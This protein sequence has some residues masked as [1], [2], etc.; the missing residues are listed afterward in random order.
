MLQI[1]TNRNSN[2]AI[3]GRRKKRPIKI[4]MT[5][6]HPQLF[7]L[8]VK[9]RFSLSVL[10]HQTEYAIKNPTRKIGPPVI[11]LSKIPLPSEI[12]KNSKVLL[13]LLL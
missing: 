12:S 4:N 13:L 10:L 7:W 9:S 3:R 1:E 2:N 5:P 6:K 11:K 8:L